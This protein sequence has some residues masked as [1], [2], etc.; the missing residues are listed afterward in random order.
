MINIFRN[1]LRRFVFDP[2]TRHSIEYLCG[3]VGKLKGYQKE[4]LLLINDRE[5]ERHYQEEQIKELQLDVE[6][7]RY[8][9]DNNAI[10]E[11]IFREQLFLRIEEIEWKMEG[12]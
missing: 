10:D 9:M 12:K 3:E 5:K 1:W 8:E 2:E 4:L 11:K 6:Q 7:L